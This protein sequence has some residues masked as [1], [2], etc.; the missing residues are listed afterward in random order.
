MGF[1]WRYFSSPVSV[2][3]TNPLFYFKLVSY[4]A[5]HGSWA[6]LT[7]N[8]VMILL[9]GPLLEEKNGSQRLLELILITAVVTAILNL[10]LFSVSV[11]GGSGICFM[12]I[13]L[14]S[15]SNIRAGEIPLTFII[16]AVLFLGNEVIAGLKP[17]NISQFSHIAGGVIGAGYGLLRF[18][19]RR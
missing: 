15:F 7:S 1:V 18:G 6:H 10:A 2:D 8:F 13:L 4:I 11:V 12:L 19:R 17:D 3:F 16:I 5:G 14:S 9:V